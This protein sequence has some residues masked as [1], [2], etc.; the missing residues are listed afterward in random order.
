MSTDLLY[1]EIP[2]AK[3]WAAADDK[4]SKTK[5]ARIAPSDFASQ[6]WN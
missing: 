2:N 5:I 1:R 4:D 6:K 3:T